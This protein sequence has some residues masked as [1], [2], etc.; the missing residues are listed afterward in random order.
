MHYVLRTYQNVI[1]NICI[2]GFCQSQRRVSVKAWKSWLNRA[3][4]VERGRF[5]HWTF[6]CIVGAKKSI[7]WIDPWRDFRVGC[8][9][10]CIRGSFSESEVNSALN[11]R[12]RESCLVFKTFGITLE[13]VYCTENLLSDHVLELGP[14]LIAQLNFDVFYFLLHLRV[15]NFG[16]LA[17]PAISLPKIKCL[18]WITIR[19]GLRSFLSLCNCLLAWWLHLFIILLFKISNTKIINFFWSK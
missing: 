14:K 11:L 17:L 19:R 5:Y 2:V 18:V 16:L 8:T 12:Q 6:F 13:T 3:V 4:V 10:S 9:A 7:L 1:L 15:S